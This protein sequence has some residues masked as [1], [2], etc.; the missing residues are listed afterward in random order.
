LTRIFADQNQISVYLRSSAANA[1]GPQFP[2]I[3]AILAI[4]PFI[5]TMN[6]GAVVDLSNE[7]ARF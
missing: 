5:V 3:L 1:F 4:G 7:K 2:A 6:M